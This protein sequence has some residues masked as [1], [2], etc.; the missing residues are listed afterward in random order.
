MD[1]GF[2]GRY[3][4]T[5]WL[6]AGNFLIGSPGIPIM[7]LLFDFLFLHSSPPFMGRNNFLGHGH[8]IGCCIPQNSLSRIGQFMFPALF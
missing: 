6:A 3:F 7:P 8:G 2:D 5:S 4:Y 1:R